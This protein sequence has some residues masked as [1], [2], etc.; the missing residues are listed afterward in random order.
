MTNRT[1][2]EPLAGEVPYL[3]SRSICPIL[4]A[5]VYDLTTDR[6]GFHRLIKL[7]WC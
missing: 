7:H 4:C 1:S 5:L 6:N 3:I 2:N